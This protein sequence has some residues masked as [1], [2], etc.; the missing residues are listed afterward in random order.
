MPEKKENR[1]AIRFPTFCTVEL[2]ENSGITRDLSTTGFCFTTGVA[3]P[4]NS[5]LRCA[6]LMPRKD[7]KIIRLRC[8]GQVVRTRKNEAGWDVAVN[9]TSFEW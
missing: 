3:F 4:I 2:D 1:A 6:I 9:F 5:M 7:G 8:E